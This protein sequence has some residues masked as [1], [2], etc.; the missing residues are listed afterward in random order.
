MNYLQCRWCLITT[1]EIIKY[2]TEQ[3]CRSTLLALST[4]FCAVCVWQYS[5]VASSAIA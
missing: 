4:G 3:C 5:N 2:N 1:T